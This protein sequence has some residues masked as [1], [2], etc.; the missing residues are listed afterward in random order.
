M[1]KQI[2]PLI[3]KYAG[4]IDSKLN[5]KLSEEEMKVQEK[6]FERIESLLTNCDIS[7]LHSILFNQTEEKMELTKQ[8]KKH[9]E[10][11]VRKLSFRIVEEAKEYMKLYERTYYEEVIKMC[12]E[13]I[14]TIDALKEL[15]RK[16]SDK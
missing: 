10:E 7:R 5:I 3:A 12:Q 6:E 13:K 15:S 16:Y 4:S 14:D 8:D 11:R 2:H 1:E 9:I